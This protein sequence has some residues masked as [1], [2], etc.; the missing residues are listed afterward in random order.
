MPGSTEVLEEI[1]ESVDGSM[2]IFVDGGLRSGVD[3]FKALALG[4]DAVLMARPFVNAVYKDGADGVRAYV[5]KIS[6]EL[7]DTM[8]MCGAYS[9][10]QI[11]KDMLYK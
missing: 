7:A 6:A 8:A 2:K 1:A 10:D 9:L 11:N 3:V 4:A 5:D